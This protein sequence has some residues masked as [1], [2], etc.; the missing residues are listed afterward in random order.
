MVPYFN[1][2]T[3][4]NGI[5]QQD[6]ATCHV[7]TST[8]R[9]FAD[10][11]IN[12]LHPPCRSPDLNPVENLWRILARNVYEGGRQFNNINNLKRQIL[13]SWERISSVTLQSLANLM[14]C[15]VAELLLKRGGHIKIHKLRKIMI[16]S[17]YMMSNKS[18]R[19]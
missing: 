11:N 5:F 13:V 14:P 7:S 2:L 16:T 1:K 10:N 19:I 3:T 15:R 4:G 6:N 12:L 8:R 9:W 18:V 17:I